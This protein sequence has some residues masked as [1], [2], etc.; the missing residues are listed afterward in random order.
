MAG[1]SETNFVLSFTR[2]CLIERVLPPI[3]SK[4][5]LSQSNALIFIQQDN[6]RPH[7]S[8]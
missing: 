1:T 5:P 4:W 3:Q 7:L 6:A 2:I 8:G